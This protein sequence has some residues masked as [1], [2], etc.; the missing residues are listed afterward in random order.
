[1]DAEVIEPGVRVQRRRHSE[2]FKAEIVRACNKPAASIAAI[3]Q[4]NRLNANLVRGWVSIARRRQAQPVEAFV[5]LQ[6]P[7]MESGGYAEIRIELQ[8]AGATIKVR[9]PVGASTECALWLRELLK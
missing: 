1:M 3:A 2:E 6:L 9:W 8:Y 5:P 4:A 7:P